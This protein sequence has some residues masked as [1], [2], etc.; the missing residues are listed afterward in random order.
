MHIGTLVLK[1]PLVNWVWGF[2]MFK[3][4]GDWGSFGPKGGG[5]GSGAR[6]P[7][8]DEVMTTLKI[9]RSIWVALAAQHYIL[10]C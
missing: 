2:R 10:L 7:T 6:D 8:V 1:L 4:R 9:A 5:G 3:K